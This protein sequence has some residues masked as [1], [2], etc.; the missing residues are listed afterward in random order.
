MD[1]TDTKMS[2]TKKT[3][4]AQMIQGQTATKSDATSAFFPFKPP[5][6]RYSG[7]NRPRFYFRTPRCLKVHKM[8]MPFSTFSRVSDDDAITENVFN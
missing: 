8:P 2:D 1:I 4:K 5:F 6:T 7:G 3:Q